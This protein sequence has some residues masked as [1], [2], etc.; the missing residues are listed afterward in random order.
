MINNNN[1]KIKNYFTVLIYIIYLLIITNIYILNQI[2]LFNKN[3]NS[4]CEIYIS[5]FFKDNI[6]ILKTLNTIFSIY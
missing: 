6:Y 1:L 5:I 3:S 4:K 2:Y